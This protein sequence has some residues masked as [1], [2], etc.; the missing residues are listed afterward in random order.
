MDGTLA[1]WDTITQYSPLQTFSGAKFVVRVAFSADGRWLAAA[2]YDKS[3]SVYEAV[4][5][6]HHAPTGDEDEDAWLHALDAGD[7]SDAAADPTLRYELRKRV[8]TEGNP[9]ALLFHPASSWLMYT[10]R[11]SHRLHYLSLPREGEAGWESRAKSFNAHAQDTHVSFSVLDLALHPSGRIIGGI[12]G[13]HAGPGAERVLLY[14]VE[15][16]E[17]ERLACLWTQSEPDAFVL[18]RLAFL[19]SGKGIITTNANGELTLLSLQGEL[20]SKL[21]V[22]A[23]R[24]G[25]AGT[26]DVVRDVV[27]VPLGEGQEG[28]WEV[29]SVGY[30]RTVKMTLGREQ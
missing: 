29:V 13:D 3:V 19:P 24:V 22:H 16:D 30:D 4:G 9:E 26:S 14:G 25:V 27:V 6:A 21:Q 12:T 1:L 28:G 18:P 23:A 10:Q 7:D 15:P 5:A 8:E 20:R 11:G 2:R 17:T